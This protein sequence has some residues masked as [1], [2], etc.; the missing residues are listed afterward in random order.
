MD[1]FE[2]SAMGNQLLVIRDE[3]MGTIR[4]Q[5]PL[6]YVKGSIDNYL[7]Q[8]HPGM[9]YSDLLRTRTSVPQV[10]GLLPNSM[11]FQQRR[12]TNEYT[13][14]PDELKHKVRFTAVDKNNNRTLQHHS[15]YH[16]TS[17][18]QICVKL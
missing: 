4:T 14:I 1:I 8:S 3:Y 9:T 11:Q 12:I 18:Q 7:A 16:E 2:Q 5:T 13:E 10:L 15:G 6:E 17:N